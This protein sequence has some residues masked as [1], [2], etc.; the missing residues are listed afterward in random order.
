MILIYRTLTNF[1]YPFL[2]VL[3][4]FRKLINKEDKN[5]Y[6]EKIFPNCF[7]VKKRQNKKEAPSHRQFGGMWTKPVEGVKW[8]A[9]RRSRSFFPLLP[10][11]VSATT[12]PPSTV[13]LMGIT[14]ARVW[15]G[16]RNLSGRGLR[17]AHMQARHIKEMGRERCKAEFSI[18]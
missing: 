14:A 3:I 4:L 13:P 18:N 17:N 1:L 16:C 5:R 2:I 7:D 10:L 15:P 9:R 11:P 6:K 12:C 8:R